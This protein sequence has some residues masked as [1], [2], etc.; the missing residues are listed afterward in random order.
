[1]SDSI[2]PHGL[3]NTRLS[4]PSLSPRFT[5]IEMVMISNHLILY[6]PLLILPSILPSLTVFSNEWLFASGSQSTRALAS[7]LPMNIQSW[8]PLGLTGLTSLH[9]Y[10]IVNNAA[11]N[12]GVHI[13]FPVNAFD[14]FQGIPKIHLVINLL[15]VISF[16]NIFFH[17]V[18]FLVFHFGNGLLWCA[19]AFTFN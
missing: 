14:V 5:S 17:S 1:M 13:Y 15:L 4:C 2:W 10:S 12:T 9:I 19:K 3:Q 6:C 8:F 16:T 18:G 11:M 7:V